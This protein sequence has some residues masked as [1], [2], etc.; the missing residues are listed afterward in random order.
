MPPPRSARERKVREATGWIICA[1]LIVLAAFAIVYWFN[2]PSSYSGYKIEFVA[3]TDGPPR[4]VPCDDT[5]F[6]VDVETGSFVPCVG[7]TGEPDFSASERTEIIVRAEQLA[8]AGG[9]GISTADER[10]LDEL[11]AQIVAR[12]RQADGPGGPWVDLAPRGMALGAAVAMLGFIALILV[13]LF[14]RR[15]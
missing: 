15:R 11:V 7:G 10:E 12:H 14:G 8:K 6:S 1:G 13:R 9:D 3:S 4:R 5:K 2:A